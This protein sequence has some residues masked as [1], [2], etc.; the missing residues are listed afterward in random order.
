MKK[1]SVRVF[2]MILAVTLAFGAFAGCN[3][4]EPAPVGP[5][6]IEISYSL[7]SFGEDWLNEAVK[8]FNSAFADKGYSAKV[9]RIDAAFVAENIANEIKSYQ[10][11]TYDLY[12]GLGNNISLVDDSFSVLRK[13]GESLLEDLTDVYNSKVINL[14][15]SEGE[16]TVLDTRNKAM[17]AYQIYNFDNEAFKGKYYGYQWTSAYGGIAVNTRVLADFGYDHAPRTTKEMEAMCD[18][19]LNQE[20]KSSYGNTIYPITWPGANA[21]GYSQYSLLTWMAQYMG[22]EGYNDFFRLKPK[23]GGST[24]EK[25]YE[26]YNDVGILYA[27]KAQETFFAQEYAASGTVTTVDHLLS[28]GILMDGEALFEFTGD[29]VY[30][31]VVGTGDYDDDELS[32]LEIIPVP[33]VS[34]LADKIGIIGSADE[35]DAVLSSIIKGVDEGKTDAQ[36]AAEI[37]QATETMAARVREARGIYYD[38]GEAHQAIIPSYSDAKDGAKLFLR[39]ISSKEFSDSIYSKKANGVTANVSAVSSD[40]NFLKSLTEVCRQTYSTPIAEGICLS[41]IRYKGGIQYTFEPMPHYGE[42]AKGMSRHA[43]EYSAQ[44]AYD[45]IRNAMKDNWDFILAAAGYNE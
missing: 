39:F 21:S 19:I 42:L 1:I 3:N 43:P 24:I 28:D 37:P 45:K 18:N 34:E 32:R 26:V 20:R 40:T 7:G 4:K 41:E 25:G 44:T 16:E 8:S 9:T 33:I 30:N 13:P 27:L 6:T 35:K 5:G 36:I 15:G 17:L 31:E 2:G 10:D 22:V 14:D 38:L 12:I 29:W 11:N 23:D